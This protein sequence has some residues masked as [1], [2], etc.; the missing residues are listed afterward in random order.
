MVAGR[1]LPRVRA[2]F[3]NVNSILLVVALVLGLGVLVW[4]WRTRGHEE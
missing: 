4:W 1:N 3:S 2:L